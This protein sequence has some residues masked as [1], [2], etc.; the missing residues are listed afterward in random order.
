MKMSN[1][2]EAKKIWSD[3]SHDQVDNETK[4]Y[5]NAQ[6]VNS[7]D[8]Y[9]LIKFPGKFLSFGIDYKYKQ[10]LPK[11]IKKLKSLTIENLQVSKSQ[12]LLTL[13]LI[14]K[15]L[16][17]TFINFIQSLIKEIS[18][19]KDHQEAQDKFVEH[20]QNFYFLFEKKENPKLS[21]QQIRG[22]FAELTFLEKLITEKSLEDPLECWKGPLNGLHD[23]E[24][25][26]T[27]FEIKSHSGTKVVS[28][29]NE[30][31]LS[32]CHNE[33]L[34][35]VSYPIIE[36]NR[37]ISLNEKIFQIKLLLNNEFLVGK[38]YRYLNQAGYFVT[39]S[40]HY[41]K[42]LLTNEHP[43]YFKITNE[44]P[45]AKLNN[46]GNEMFN[47]S[48]QLDLNKCDNWKLDIIKIA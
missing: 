25:G 28:I 44:F 38:F 5:F 39:H 2:L 29:L 33:E 40:K 32:P 41:E 4:F 10:F 26:K 37:G 48:Y 27:L 18:S 7:I 21:K 42:L 47:I 6:T 31:Q 23:F 22:L 1:I 24:I 19:C 46:L 3:L 45:T 35:L 12:K 20:I 30:D 15:E 17:S 9:F 13:T 16:K 34:Y 43:S 11:E 36:S 14:N 8:F